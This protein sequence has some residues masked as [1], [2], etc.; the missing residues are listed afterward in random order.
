VVGNLKL[1]E[2][3][4]FFSK[5]NI[6]RESLEKIKENLS[7]EETLKKLIEELFSNFPSKNC[8][9]NINDLIYFFKHYFSNKKLS[10]EELEKASGGA[11]SEIG[12]LAL[13]LA[14]T[15]SSV[16]LAFVPEAKS[17]TATNLKENLKLKQNKLNKNKKINGIEFSNLKDKAQKNTKEKLF[18]G[19][20]ELKEEPKFKISSKDLKS[21]N[22]NSNTFA[23]YRFG[24]IEEERVLF[25]NEKQSGNKTLTVKDTPMTIKGK[26]L[27]MGRATYSAT[28]FLLDNDVNISFN[29]QKWEQIPENNGKKILVYKDSEIYKKLI[30]KKSGNF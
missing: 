20:Y 8:P 30:N 22:F 13:G 1:K 26:Y 14:D 10:G 19:G 7:N 3:Y 29:D 23:I 11:I 27:P 21:N 9:F 17:G 2:I 4:D 25:F 12:M 18:I 15:V 5:N 24:D 16:G 6:P 28:A